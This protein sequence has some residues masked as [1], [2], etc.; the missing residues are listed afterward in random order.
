MGMA[1]LAGAG[2]GMQPYGIAQTMGIS[3]PSVVMAQAEG[4]IV[5][6]VKSAD[7]MAEVDSTAVPT[8]KS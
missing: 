6:E 5:D 3:M 1:G 7:K 4:E 8:I 2:W